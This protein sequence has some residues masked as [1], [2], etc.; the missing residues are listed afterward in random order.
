[1]LFGEM[2]TLAKDAQRGIKLVPWRV[3]DLGGAIRNIA[4]Q[5]VPRLARNVDMTAPMAFTQVLGQNPAW[6]RE[7]LDRVRKTTAKPVLSFLQTDR[8]IRPEEITA[9]QF[10]SELQEALAP[11]WAG[12]VVFE[13]GQ[14]A[15]N[16][17][18]AAILRKHLKGC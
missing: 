8:L 15:A 11:E 4:G 6:K 1:M 9:A 16:P 17:V 7:L 10:E 3:Q 18:K 12:V 5:D 14:L 13:Y 2:R